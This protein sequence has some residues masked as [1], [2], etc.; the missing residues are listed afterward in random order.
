MHRQRRKKKKQS[1]GEIAGEGTERKKKKQTLWHPVL[2]HSS[3]TLG[4]KRIHLKIKIKS[5]KTNTVFP[6][7]LCRQQSQQKNIELLPT[8]FKSI[9]FGKQ[10]ASLCGQPPPSPRPQ[11]CHHTGW[12][13]I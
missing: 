10:K 7:S 13:F 5:S 9:Y 11:Y 2:F 8:P 3:G 4:N 6:N 12:N 1:C